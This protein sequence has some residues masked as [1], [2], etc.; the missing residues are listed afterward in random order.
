MELRIGIAETRLRL[1]HRRSPQAYVN[2]E[3]KFA[4]I[5]DVYAPPMNNPDAK[6][7]QFYEDLYALLATVSKADKLIV[8]GDFNTRVGTDNA[9]RR[10]VLGPHGLNGHNNNNLLLLQTFAEH[11]LI[12]TNTFFRLPMRK[13][14]IWKPPRSR[15]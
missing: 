7:D 8:L 1:V 2:V 4:T 13:K 11:R 15:Q 12:L 14:A 3:G 10:G 9:A 5:T 6:R